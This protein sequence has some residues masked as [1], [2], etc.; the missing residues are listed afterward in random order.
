MIVPLKQR[1]AGDD[2]QILPRRNPRVPSYV[3]PSMQERH[4]QPI[5]RLS[6]AAS[7][8]DLLDRLDVEKFPK[9]ERMAVA[10][11]RVEAL[12]E[13]LSAFLDMTAPRG[14]RAPSSLQ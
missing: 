7:V 13:W 12:D 14:R 9:E 2:I 8:I 5:D 4:R 3:P 6:A 10:L 11:V 1:S